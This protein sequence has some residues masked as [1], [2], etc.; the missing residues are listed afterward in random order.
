MNKLLLLLGCS[1]YAQSGT[2]R[3]DLFR[4]PQSCPFEVHSSFDACQ[5]NFNLSCMLPKLSALC[6]N[7]LCLDYDC[8]P[9]CGPCVSPF[10]EVFDAVQASDTSSSGEVFV[11]ETV[12]VALRNISEGDEE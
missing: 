3:C 12:I 8:P 10:E 1:V 5:N 9:P 4:V 6:A 11:T 2:V 7:C